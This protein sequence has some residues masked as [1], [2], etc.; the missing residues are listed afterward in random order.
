MKRRVFLTLFLVLVL[1]LAGCGSTPVS[2]LE[3]ERQIKTVINTYF[4]AMLVGDYETAR[5]CFHPDSPA[6]ESFDIT[7]QQLAPILADVQSMGCS[8]TASINLVNI[9]INGDTAIATIDTVDMCYYCNVYDTDCEQNNDL[10]GSQIILKRYA[11]K[12]YIY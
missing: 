10:Y 2:E 1:F 9:D 8:L 6:Q 5:G 4:N 3:D 11:G 7:V 12:W